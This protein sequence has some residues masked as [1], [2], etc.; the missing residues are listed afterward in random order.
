MS[1][2]DV[3][4]SRAGSV[5][6]ASNLEQAL[7]AMGFRCTV[8]AVDRLAVIVADDEVAEREIAVRRREALREIG[9]H[10]F[11]HLALEVLAEPIQ[12]ATLH[13]D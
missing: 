10:G 1:D 4:S 9:T 3:L 6:S 2:P 5:G 11:T 13:R 12:R 8:E 7:R